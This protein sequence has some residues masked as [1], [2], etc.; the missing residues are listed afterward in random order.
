MRELLYIPAGKIIRFNDG[1]EDISFEERLLDLMRIRHNIT[2]EYSFLLA[3]VS[4]ELSEA[5]YIK[6]NIQLPALLDE[7]E[8]IELPDKD[9]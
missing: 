5:F 1:W 3:I 2:S 6:H 7:F 4:G 9:S 8:L